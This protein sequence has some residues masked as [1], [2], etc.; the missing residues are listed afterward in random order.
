MKDKREGERGGLMLNEWH[1]RRSD[2]LKSPL[3]G[4]ISL[5]WHHFSSL[6][7][8]PFILMALHSLSFLS[9]SL[10]LSS[11]AMLTRSDIVAFFRRDKCVSLPLSPSPS[12]SLSHLNTN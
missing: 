11:A 4:Y 5:S 9:F 6:L 12:L 8:F 10:T 7:F 2:S 1:G 3:C